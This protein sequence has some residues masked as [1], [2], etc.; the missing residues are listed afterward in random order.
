MNINTRRFFIAALVVILACGVLFSQ[1]KLDVK[2][3]FKEKS[4]LKGIKWGVIYF[5]EKKGCQVVE[6]GEHFAVWLVDFQEKRR[7]PDRYT[8]KLTVKITPPSLFREK[9]AV[10]SEVVEV[11]YRFQP[12]MLNV[13]DTG[14]LEF[15]KEKYKNMAREEI[16]RA[17]HVGR[18]AARE[19]K[20]M[21]L[22][23]RQRKTKKI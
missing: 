23:L 18:M 3:K 20:L 19:I 4:E 7:A 13:D 10:A 6:V 16:V 8:A 2:T 22:V 14:F 17:F 5:L 12:G 1:V 15:F 11:K 21:L 9:K